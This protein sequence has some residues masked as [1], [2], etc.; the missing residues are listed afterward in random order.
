ML[1][2]RQVVSRHFAGSLIWGKCSHQNP[3][4]LK[5]VKVVPLFRQLQKRV[6]PSNKIGEW[7]AHLRPSKNGLY[8]DVASDQLLTATAQG[9]RRGA[10][11]ELM[12]KIPPYFAIQTTGHD[13]RSYSHAFDYVNASR[14]ALQLGN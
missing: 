9:F 12:C 6:K 13:M 5:G 1:C 11:N 14:S 2:L 8:K 3:E 7:I 4:F 10:I